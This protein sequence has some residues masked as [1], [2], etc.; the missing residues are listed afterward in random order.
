[1]KL[2][3]PGYKERYYA[4]KFGVKEPKLIDDVKRDVVSHWFVQKYVEGLCWIMRYYYQGVCSW[5][6]LVLDF[7]NY[8]ILRSQDIKPFPMLWHEDNNG[9]RQNR[10]SF[11]P[12]VSGALSGH[13]LGEAAHRLVKNS[14]QIRSNNNT[15][16]L[17][18]PYRNV[19]NFGNKSRPAGP[20]GYERGFFE[21]SNYH[22]YS[23]S[24]FL[25]F[26]NSR[27]K[28]HDGAQFSRQNVRMQGMSTSQGQHDSIRTE[29]SRLTVGEGP[30]LQ[31]HVQMPNAGGS[32][33]HQQQLIQN[34]GPPPPFPPMDWIDKQMTRGFGGRQEP[35]EWPSRQPL[36]RGNHA[37]GFGRYEASTRSPNDKQQQQQQQQANKV[38]R[39]K[40]QMPQEPPDSST[41]Q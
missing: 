3:E 33:Y 31:P 20:L 15:G 4:E 2:G 40:L 17:D 25:G 38:Y 16:L 19:Q 34:A 6:W 24:S 29:M 13:L 26:S 36:V 1:V 37:G 21:D 22:Q 14:L 9:R 18:A 7:G 23:S 8:Y 10:E 12:Q 41:Q 27:P 28:F 32:S 30:K 39:I 11:R 35:T 5:Q